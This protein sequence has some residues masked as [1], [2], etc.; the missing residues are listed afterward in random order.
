MSDKESQD[1]QRAPQPNDPVRLEPEAFDHK[2]TAS[3]APAEFIVGTTDHATL[4]D[5]EEGL[6]YEHKNKEEGSLARFT[7]GIIFGAIFILGIISLLIYRNSL[8][9]ED[10]DKQFSTVLEDVQREHGRFEDDIVE[11]ALS[12]QDQIT[13]SVIGFVTA[14]TVNDRLRFSRPH[15][16]LEERMRD[17]YANNTLYNS[18]LS[19]DGLTISETSIVD[20]IH[21][22]DVIV[23]W[24]GVGK[25]ALP[26]CETD[27]G[28]KV[29]W[30]A[31]EVWQPVN[32]REFAIG[33]IQGSH[34]FR[35]SIEPDDLYLSPY[36]PKEYI[37]VRLNSVGFGRPLY[38]YIERG[39]KIE[40]K[41]SGQLHS[42]RKG[43]RAPFKMIL[44]LE[45]VSTISRSSLVKIVDVKA[46][47]WLMPHK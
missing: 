16:L 13:E 9:P 43:D 39:S 8:E 15:S 25:V 17:F 21:F 40:E 2:S 33:K 38:A 12:L 20:G 27:N 31:V 22:H 35:T 44:E 5:L 18:P 46:S 7:K 26:V 23:R 41:L 42:W 11:E 1:I 29:D 30:E 14:A 10:T 37:S 4:E 24:Q 6:F 32:P 34:N 19:A 3:A 36:T 45:F 47:S 28:Y